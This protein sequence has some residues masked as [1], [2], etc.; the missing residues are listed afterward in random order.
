MPVV[1]WRKRLEPSA[2]LHICRTNDCGKVDCGR[3][4]VK[5]AESPAS[6]CHPFTTAP[7]DN[8]APGSATNDTGASTEPLKFVPSRT[9]SLSTY[10][11]VSN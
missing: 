4:A 2:A 7:P 3:L 8:T 9:V 11:P 10:V 5:S 6:C 1:S